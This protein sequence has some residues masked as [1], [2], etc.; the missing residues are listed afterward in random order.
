[1]D[2][3]SKYQKYK[4]KYLALKQNAGAIKLA[5]S[6]SF[7]TEGGGEKI[8]LLSVPEFNEVVDN[9][10]IAD[11]K[12]NIQRDLF[13][14]TNLTHEQLL[15][16]DNDV[17]SI[18]RELTAN[19]AYE[20][21]FKKFCSQSRIK[22]IDDPA[23]PN[24]YNV[25]SLKTYLRKINKVTSNNFFRGFVNWN[26]YDD[27]T[28]DIKM[29]STTVQNLRNSTI[30]FFANFSFGKDTNITI[31]NQLLFLNSL[32]H[33]G[34]SEINIVLPY[35]PVGTMERIV[36]EGEIPTGYSFAHL[37]NSIPSGGNK[38]NIVILDIHAL[39]SRF[40]FHTNLRPTLVSVLPKF[41]NYLK[42]T[43]PDATN[44]NIIVFPDDGAKKRFEKLLPE[45]YKTILCSKERKGEERVI[46]I[47]DGLNNI[48]ILEA[49]KTY[50]LCIIDDLVQ[51]GGTIAETVKGLKKFIAENSATG[52]ITGFTE[53]K[54]KYIAMITHT[55]A[56]SDEKFVKFMESVDKFV[57]T[58]SRPIRTKQIKEMAGVSAKIDVLDISD[59]IH[60]VFVNQQ[61]T[62]Y[63]APNIIN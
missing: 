52:K 51:S 31:L 2:I 49:G 18:T 38:N 33:Y 58:N 16:I 48:E 7:T 50:N 20:T 24:S 37:L 47:D 6:P 11:G 54:I 3:K 30:I 43:F 63:I 22:F 10:I 53:D 4:E 44:E 25:N 41:L 13:A 62:D 57:T 46:K 8:I 34:V 12:V 36:G 14:K 27:S 42:K 28:P 5:H 32:S 59:I 60:D 26:V 55:V 29:D 17:E 40:F 9:F 45:G 1:M 39:C 21:K 15:E 56:P 19:K 35:F 61:K 23:N